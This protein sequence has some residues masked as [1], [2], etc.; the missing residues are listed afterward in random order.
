MRGKKRRR[1]PRRQNAVPDGGWIWG[2]H[3]VETALA[4]P[5]RRIKRLLIAGEADKL[6]I[7]A[8]V[9][10]ENAG[11]DEIS[12]LLPPDAVHQGIALLADPLPD[13]AIEDICA[14]PAEK[15]RST[16]VILDQVTDP[17]NVGAVLR[18]AAVFGADAVILPD[19]NAP[20]MTGTLAKSSSGAIES[21]PLI[22]VT[23]LVRAM[24]SLKQAGYWCIGLDSEAGASLET[25]KSSPYQA[26]ALGA[27]GPG[28][29]RLTRE[30][31]DDFCRIE[32]TGPLHSLNVSNAAAVALFALTRQ[33]T[34]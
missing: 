11:K 6:T 8:G 18:S 3:P 16:I 31:C 23:N 26:I 4:N 7:P 22:R 1:S 27:E 28:L 25:L 17:H 33:A 2:R 13:L 9:T 5:A 19:R 21:V 32:A 34:D 15:P 12:D 24:E 20:P 30:S 10:P 14:I 29:R